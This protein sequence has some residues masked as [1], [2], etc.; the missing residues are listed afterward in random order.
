MCGIFAVLATMLQGHRGPDKAAHS[1]ETLANGWRVLLGHQRLSILDLSDA[2]TQ[3]MR[4]NSGRQTIIFNGEIYN[5]L[6]LAPRMRSPRRTGTDTEVLLELIELNGLSA[7]LDEA[8]GM[9]ALVHVDAAQNVIQLARDRAGEKPLYIWRDGRRMIV[10]S[11]MKTVA[12][13]AG[14]RFCINPQVLSDYI[15]QGLQDV[16]EQTWL[17]GIEQL[18]PASSAR[19]AWDAAGHLQLEISRYWKP[20]AQPVE[21]NRAE[22]EARLRDLMQ[23]SLK[24]RL[25]AD[26]PVGITL[27]G[28]LDSSILA[29]EMARQMGD[30]SRVHAISSVAPGAQGDESVHINRVCDALGVNTHRVNLGEDAHENAALLPEVTWHNDAPLGSFSNIAFFRLMRLARDQ[31]VIVV[32]SGQGADEAFCGYRK[33]FFWAL[34]DELRRRQFASGLGN[35]VGSLWQGTVLRQFNYSEA[36]RYLPGRHHSASALQASIRASAGRRD[37][38]MGTR[39]LGERQLE[40]IRHYSVPYLTHYEDRQSMAHGVEVRLPYLDH[41]I[42]EFGLSLPTELKVSN[43]WTKSVM[44]TA[45]HQVLP[46]EIIWRRDKQGFSNPQEEWLRGPLRAQLDVLFRGDAAVY[47]YGLLDRQALIGLW[48]RFLAG[49]R[50]VAHRQIFAAWALEAWL[51]KF[52]AYLG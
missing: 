23:D 42:I 9:W 24:I 22:A 51:G 48:E 52:S 37:V 13:L 14:R 25:R 35:V 50:T 1:I 46:H 31:G 6:E 47:Q 39:T 41:R 15:D 21:I 18:P 38:S 28:G 30:P 3:P 7:T 27:S 10:A 2:G 26:V 33:Y 32:L 4:S 11:E 29:A 49:D 34:R 40:D 45:F 44:R 19:I 8:N 43:G 36:K 20:S 17:T 12:A 5:Y 16:D